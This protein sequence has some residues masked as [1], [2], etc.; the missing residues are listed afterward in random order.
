[1]LRGNAFG[2]R[3]ESFRI[4]EFLFCASSPPERGG[5]NSASDYFQ[6]A[7]CLSEV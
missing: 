3:Q 5:G 2:L 1:M 6:I 7:I 4:H